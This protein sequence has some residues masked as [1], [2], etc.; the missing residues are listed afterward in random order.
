IAI[1][2]GDLF[3]VCRFRRFVPD[4][5]ALDNRI[6]RFRCCFH[7]GGGIIGHESSQPTM[8]FHAE[9]MAIAERLSELPRSRALAAS[10]SS[11]VFRFD[12]GPPSAAKSASDSWE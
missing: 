8:Q 10:D 1:N 12:A 7:D 4:T 11:K 9:R 3:G 6:A 2:R 5:T